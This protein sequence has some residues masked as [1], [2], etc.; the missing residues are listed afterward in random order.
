MDA[1]RPVTG[2]CRLCTANDEAAL[3]EEVAAALWQSRDERAWA[4]AGPSWQRVFRELAE[5]AVHALRHD[6]ARHGGVETVDLR[7]RQA[8]AAA[9]P[10]APPWRC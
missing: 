4:D 3:I 7:Q 9:E 10:S 2:R 6:A 5:T 8:M 1:E